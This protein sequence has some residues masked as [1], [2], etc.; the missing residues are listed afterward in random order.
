ME[1]KKRSIGRIVRRCILLMAV[2]LIAG[3]SIFTRN[4]MQS[5]FPRGDYPDRRF[6]TMTRFSELEPAYSREMVSFRSGDNMLVGYIYGAENE[7]GLIVWSHGIGCGHEAYLEDILWFADRGWRVFAYDGTG[8]GESEGSGSRGLAQSAQDLNC[9]LD[10]VERD[11]RLAGIPV[12]LVGHS[13]GGYAAGAVLN[14]DHRVRAAVSIS[15]Y[16]DPMEMLREGAD[17]ML[18]KVGST[19]S[20]PFLWGYNRLLFGANLNLTAAEGISHS[21]VPVLVLH[22]EHD[23]VISYDR[24]SILS[25]Q[26]QITNPNVTYETLT[27]EYADHMSFLVSDAANAYRK[28]RQADFDALRA[29][30][31]GTLTD[32]QKIAFIEETDRVLYN[33]CN[34]EL[35]EHIEQF[36]TEH[37]PQTQE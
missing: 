9:A 16:S 36:M 34:S 28:E 7:K 31:G 25:K 14:Y 26:D 11:L 20:Y 13:W 10:F 4:A 22:G 12:M 5:E 37:L 29:Q 24:C 23:E 6:S 32:E 27:G 8:S 18:G 3:G 15:G 33:A 19:L 2:L 17:E 35:L 1:Q 21:T 30:N